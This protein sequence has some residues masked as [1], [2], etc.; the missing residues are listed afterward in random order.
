MRLAFS[1]AESRSGR[2]PLLALLVEWDSCDEPLELACLD[3]MR[4]HSDKPMPAVHRN[5]V[6]H[7]LIDELVPEAHARLA[8][9]VGRTQR[10]SFG[11]GIFEILV[12]D[13]CVSNDVAVMV[14]NGDL[15]VGIDGDEPGLV[16]LELVQVD[17]NTLKLEPLFLQR[18]QGFERVGAWLGV[19]KLEHA[20]DPLLAWLPGRTL[21]S[22][23]ACPEAVERL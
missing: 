16:L 20:S 11:K 17:V 22:N 19:I 23:A 15:A 6:H 10:R 2:P 21:Q 13:G 8:Q 18:N 5:V 12:D 3:A 1:C 14:Q 9:G 7:V 4:Q